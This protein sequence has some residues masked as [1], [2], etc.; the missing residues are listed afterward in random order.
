MNI[1]EILDAFIEDQ[2]GS[3]SCGTKVE[4]IINT[5]GLSQES[6][7]N[8]VKRYERRRDRDKN[9]LGHY[10][11]FTDMSDEQVKARAENVRNISLR[12]YTI[13]NNR[14]KYSTD[15]LALLNK[16]KEYLNPEELEQH[17][18][19]LDEVINRIEDNKKDVYKG[20]VEAQADLES[21][22][23]L[24]SKESIEV[25]IRAKQEDVDKESESKI[26]V[27]KDYHTK[28]SKLADYIR[29]AANELGQE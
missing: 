6:I 7:D 11:N 26:Q 14:Y 23:N 8:V 16:V 17:K 27:I 24:G 21:T 12:R 29:R 22:T 20:L 28:N 5:L 10:T 3:K 18:E 25:Y 13:L 4:F 9:L 19:L 15:L 1:A 2:Q